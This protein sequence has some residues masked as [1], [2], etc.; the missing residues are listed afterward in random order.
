[1]IHHQLCFW[2]AA[3][4]FLCHRHNPKAGAKRTY[5]FLKAAAVFSEKQTSPSNSAASHKICVRGGFTDTVVGLFSVTSADF[6]GKQMRE[7]VGSGSP[8]NVY[9]K[10]TL[11]TDMK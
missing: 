10:D 6:A 9:F 1:M 3:L 8:T 2:A 4:G 5:F 7:V 11:V